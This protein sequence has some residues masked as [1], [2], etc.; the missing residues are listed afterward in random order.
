MLLGVPDGQFNIPVSQC[1]FFNKRITGTL[2]GS[3]SKIEEMLQFCSE[4]NI[5]A[6]VQVYPIEKVNEAFVDF[7]AGKPRYRFVLQIT[8]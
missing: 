7:V 3:P 6:D 2:I 4:H 5:V 1:V 8:Q